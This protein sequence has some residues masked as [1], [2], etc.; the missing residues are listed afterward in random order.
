M[1]MCSALPGL[2]LVFCV[3]IFLEEWLEKSRGGNP[4][5]DPPVMIIKMITGTLA[6]KKSDAPQP[7]RHPAI[8][9]KKG[10]IYFLFFENPTLCVVLFSV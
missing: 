6:R 9:F 8:D 10:P 2:A 7:I 3:G 4:F 1:R 5:A